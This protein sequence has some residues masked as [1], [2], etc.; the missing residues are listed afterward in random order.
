M[1]C[2]RKTEEICIIKDWKDEMKSE[3]REA[4]KGVLR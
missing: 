1:K 3:G 4:G 2:F